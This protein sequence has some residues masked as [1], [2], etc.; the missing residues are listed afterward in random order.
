MEPFVSTET[1][2][3]SSWTSR[4]LDAAKST[5]SS[6]FPALG[7]VDAAREFISEAVAQQI[8]DKACVKA[9]ALIAQAHRKVIFSIVWQN[10]LLMLSMVPV[11]FL[12]SPWPFY[13]A[14]ACVFGYTLYSAYEYRAIIWRLCKTFSVT[15]T[16]A[17]EVREAIE[18]ELMEGQLIQRKAVEWLGPDLERLS[19][20]VARKLK[21]DVMGAAFNMAFTLFMAFIAFRV[22]VIPLLEHRALMH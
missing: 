4:L 1:K 15:R 3:S 13:L 12:R 6:V 21:P 2:E 10:G 11:Y 17:L 19:E 9:Q 7:A 22:F 18:T 20:D 8:R 5:L 14:Y 16:L